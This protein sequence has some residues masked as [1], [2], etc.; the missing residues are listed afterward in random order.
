MLLLVYLITF[1]L[2][3]KLRRKKHLEYEEFP[4]MQI[5]KNCIVFQSFSQH[6]IMLNGFKYLQNENKIYLKKGKIFY[7][8]LNVDKVFKYE[9]FLYFTALGKVKICYDFKE[10]YKYFNIEIKSNKFS[11][12][13]LKQKAIMDILSNGFQL[14]ICEDL[15]RYMSVLKNIFNVKIEDNR[16]VIGQNK[17]KLSFE[18]K[19]KL[20]HKIK[21][22]IVNETL[23]EN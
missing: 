4:A 13:S 7:I 5:K 15:K 10:I 14:E 20:N 2:I 16:I 6:R 21:K 23:E 19:Y 18:V 12:E 3:I 22:V 1:H 11:L 8:I 9:D 17:L